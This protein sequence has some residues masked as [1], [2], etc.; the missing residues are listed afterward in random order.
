MK[1]SKVDRRVKYTKMV[2]KDGLVQLM[3]KQHISCISVKSLCDIADI[4]RSTFYT[5]YT[6][7][8]DLLHYIEEEVMANLRLHLEE[9]DYA[10]NL[11]VSAQV[12]STIFQYAKDNADLFKV[13]L[14]ENCD[15]AFQKDVLSLSQI[16][17]NQYSM[18]LDV[19]TKEYLEAY[20]ITGCISIFHKWLNDGTIESVAT[21]TELILQVLYN[22]ITS[23]QGNVP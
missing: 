13:L 8:Y 11:P 4:N 19:R 3:Q 5:H 20:G 22:G 6:D 15:F 18:A 2:L 12:V 17:S 1:D 16:V 10:N 14:S 7:Q 23:F 9:Q 21:I